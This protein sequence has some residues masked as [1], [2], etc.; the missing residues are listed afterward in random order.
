MDP[1][2]IVDLTDEEVAAEITAQTADLFKLRFQLAT[3]QLEN[4]AKIRAVRKNLARLK[5]AQRARE[6][7]AG[8][9]A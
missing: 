5:T 3:G 7:K 8:V 6:I 9:P 1:K 4:P 2:K